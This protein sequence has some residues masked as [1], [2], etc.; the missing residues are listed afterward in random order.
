LLATPLKI[1]LT[2]QGL[3]LYN[4]RTRTN[5]KITQGFALAQKI[6]APKLRSGQLS[7]EAIVAGEVSA[8]FALR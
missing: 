6:S 2:S 3:P 8:Y 1:H 4:G 7:L 5:G